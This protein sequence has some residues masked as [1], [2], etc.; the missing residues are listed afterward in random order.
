[1]GHDQFVELLFEVTR[2]KKYRPIYSFTN[3]HFFISRTFIPATYRWYFSSIFFFSRVAWNRW[4]LPSRPLFG[5]SFYFLSKSRYIFFWHFSI[6]ATMKSERNEK[7][8]RS[9]GRQAHTHTHTHNSKFNYLYIV[10][11]LV[12]IS[13]SS[14]FFVF[15]SGNAK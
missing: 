1:M 7:P 8:P 3:S 4:M 12:Y 5:D 14:R 2:Q 10:R 15:A 11:S 9:I 6:D 13:S